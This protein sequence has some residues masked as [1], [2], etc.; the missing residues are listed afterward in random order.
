M[1]EPGRPA[2]VL[3]AQRRSRREYIRTHHP[4]AGGKQ[5][6]FISGLA[7]FDAAQRRAGRGGTPVTV[8]VRPAWPV[9]LT[10][11][12][13]RRLLRRHQPPRVR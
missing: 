10:T 3:A 6:D 7:D 4:D 1:S 2:D 13:L 8:V 12:L 11:V 9:S 5:E